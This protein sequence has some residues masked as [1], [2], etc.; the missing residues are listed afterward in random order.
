MTLHRMA[1]HG[2]SAAA[3]ALLGA[4]ALVA[5]KKDKPVNQDTAS[6]TTTVAPRIPRDHIASGELV[7]GSAKVYALPLPYGFN[8]TAVSKEGTNAY[9]DAPKDEVVESILSRVRD[10]KA[11]EHEGINN[12][13]GVKVP[14]EPARLLDIEVRDA[15]RYGT[16][17]LVKDV[18]PPPPAV[19]TAQEEILK[20]AG[21]DPK[22]HVTDPSKLE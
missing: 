20:A 7:E 12:F 21:L 16:L 17:I 11:T 15:P 2:P 3:V 8:V 6:P 19:P 1:R 14:A 4:L 9:G 22:G 18:T 13:V 5:C 10:G